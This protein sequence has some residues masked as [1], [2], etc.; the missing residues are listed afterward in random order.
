MRQPLYNRDFC[1]AI[2]SMIRVQPEGAVYDLTGPDRIDYIDMIRVIRD[3]K[4]L[5]TPIVRVPVPLFA[6]ALRVYALFSE[7]PP[8]TAE[9]LDSLTA[10]DDF[11]GVDL[12]AVFG[13]EPTPF[14]EAI[15]E[16]FSHPAYSSVVLDSPH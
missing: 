3:T 4:G 11:T 6:A 16:T 15:R 1:R 5:K 8:F 10:G 14:R 2:I 7:K 12:Q 9:Q 13:F